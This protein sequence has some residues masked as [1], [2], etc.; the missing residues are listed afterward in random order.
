MISR[1]KT[2]IKTK[3]KKHSPSKNIQKRTFSSELLQEGLAFITAFRPYATFDQL[4]I[5]SELLF[6]QMPPEIHQ[7]GISF[8]QTLAPQ[9]KLEELYQLES[10]LPAFKTPLIEEEK[11]RTTFEKL[12]SGLIERVST[13]FTIADLAAFAATNKRH[14][15]SFFK[16]GSLLKHPIAHYLHQLQQLTLPRYTKFKFDYKKKAILL[17]LFHETFRLSHMNVS[18]YIKTTFTLLLYRILYFQLKSSPPDKYAHITKQTIALEKE[19]KL[20]AGKREHFFIYH[21]RLCIPLSCEKNIV[22]NLAKLLNV[23][24]PYMDAQV[25]KEV[26]VFHSQNKYINEKDEDALDKEHHWLHL[27]LLPALTAFLPFL[28]RK[29][30]SQKLFEHFVMLALKDNPPEESLYSEKFK[31][32]FIGDYYREV[33][34]YTPYPGGGYKTPDSEE[35]EA[36]SLPDDN[37]PD[38]DGILIQSGC[39]Q[40]SPSFR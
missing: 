11:K 7:Q 39:S 24:H 40:H 37:I 10:A 1:E 6:S 17:D 20:N 12:C 33:A 31:I 23:Y 38:D 21:D 2:K 8:F 18:N 36:Y 27:K 15:S 5:L 19:N 35:E 16:A 4:R 28:Q 22:M 26:I 30:Q 14:H 34:G 25:C 3:E 13:Y 9:L 29:K 32:H